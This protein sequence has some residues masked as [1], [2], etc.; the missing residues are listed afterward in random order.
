MNGEGEESE[1]RVDFLGEDSMKIEDLGPA[2]M[3]KSIE[4]V[5]FEEQKAV[6]I[7][8]DEEPVP[9]TNEKHVKATQEECE[10]NLTDSN[11]ISGRLLPNR[12]SSAKSRKSSV[13]SLRI[14]ES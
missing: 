13:K 6:M 8:L 3:K 5:N 11:H 7:D 1:E 14:S 9:E 4:P 10:A 2:G 12:P